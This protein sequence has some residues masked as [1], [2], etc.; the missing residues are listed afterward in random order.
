MKEIGKLSEKATELLT[1][2]VVGD[3]NVFCPMDKSVLQKSAISHSRAGSA[4]WDTPYARYQ[5]YNALD[6]SKSHNPFA[7]PKWFEAAKAERL[8]EWTALVSGVIREET[9]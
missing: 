9:L 1:L 7:R 8:D 2:K 3:S 6:H 5:Y 4:V